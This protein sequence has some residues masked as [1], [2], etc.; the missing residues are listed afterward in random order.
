MV[1]PV[2]YVPNIFSVHTY[3]NFK[4][5]FKNKGKVPMK[6]TVKDH[7]LRNAGLGSLLCTIS[8]KHWFI[9]LCLT[10]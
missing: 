2:E 7:K 4:I 8:Y 6:P 1:F 9:P 10:H 3:T 5:P